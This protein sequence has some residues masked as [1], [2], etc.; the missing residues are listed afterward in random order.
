MAL[1]PGNGQLHG[2]LAN[3]YARQGNP[4]AAVAELETALQLE[5]GNALLHANL[6]FAL[7]RLGRTADA[8]RHLSRALEIAPGMTNVRDLLARLQP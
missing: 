1:A 3:A 7:A 6:G 2:N 5:P 8:R 4:A